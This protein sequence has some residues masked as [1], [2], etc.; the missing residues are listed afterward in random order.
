MLSVSTM[1]SK[2]VMARQGF[3]VTSNCTVDQALQAFNVTHHATGVSSR[4]ARSMLH[5]Y[6][7]AN[8]GASTCVLGLPKYLQY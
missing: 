2:M 5:A 3:S 7:G 8:S 1:L 6:A 4:K